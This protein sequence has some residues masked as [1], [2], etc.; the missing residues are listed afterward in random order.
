[1][2]ALLFATIALTVAIAVLCFHALRTLGRFDFA[3]AVAAAHY[4]SSAQ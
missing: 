1:M 3:N 4:G 2:S